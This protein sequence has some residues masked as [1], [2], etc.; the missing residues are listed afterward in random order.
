[1]S[2]HCKLIDV[3]GTI[4]VKY[5]PPVNGISGKTFLV[6]SN[7]NQIDHR[8]LPIGS[9]FFVPLDAIPTDWPWYNANKDDLSDYY[10]EHNSHRQPLF[11]ILP[12]RTLFLIDGKC[13]SN[14]KKYGGWQVSGEAEH[15]TVHPSINIGGSYHG[16]LQ[17]GVISEDVE[18]RTF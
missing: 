7:D 18:G 9:M 16:W 1:M 12:D 4:H 3:A 14:G 2:W 13:W 5:D 10:F 8:S 11:V 6:D 17:N 15:I